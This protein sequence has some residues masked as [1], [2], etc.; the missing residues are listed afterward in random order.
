MV[1]ELG[2]PRQAFPTRSPFMAYPAVQS[3]GTRRFRLDNERVQL[4]SGV[5]WTRDWTR[6]RGARTGIL[7]H[8]EDANRTVP[9]S[10]VPLGSLGLGSSRNRTSPS[11][12]SWRGVQL[13]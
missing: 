4:D 8:G 11:H 7:G 13:N 2:A 12:L 5:N 1:H 9:R 10:P 3:V 6:G